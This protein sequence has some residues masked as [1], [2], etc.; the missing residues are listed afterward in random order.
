MEV[1]EHPVERSNSN[2]AVGRLVI[3][4][5][6]FLTGAQVIMIP[7][8]IVINALTARY[9]GAS[10]FGYIYL[11]GTICSF[12]FLVVEWGQAGV[13]PAAIAR[14][15]GQ[16]SAFLGT[17]VAWRVMLV[18]LVYPAL[19]L[20][21]HL[22]GYNAELQ[23][24]LALSFALATLSSFSNAFKDTIRGFERTDLPAYAQ[25][26][27]Q[28]LCALLIAPVLVFGGRMR[29]ALG[30]QVFVAAV[31][32]VVLWPALRLVG[33]RTLSFQRATL[34]SLL[35]EGTPFVF[36]NL[37][38]ALQPNIDAVFLSRLAPDEVMGWFAVTRRLLGVL[39]F[40]ASALLSALYPT[41]SRLHVSDQEMFNRTVRGSLY[42]IALLVVPVALGCA[43]YPEIGIS[44]FSRESFGPAEDNL[45]VSALFLFLVYFSM[46]L[47]TCI[48]AAGKQRA[49]SVV[50]SLC[51]LVSLVLDPILVPVFQRRYGN[52]GL[53]LCVAGV[54]SELLVV[55]CGIALAPKGIFDRRF[56]RLVGLAVLSGVAMALTA[57]GL[58]FLSLTPFLAAPLAVLVY[59]GALLL[60]GAIDKN[61]VASVRSMLGRKFSRP[62]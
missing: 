62:R 32:V 1:P 21:C 56:A 22:F 40:P 48:L 33:V 35:R 9:L 51:V 54:V 47:G 6:L 31:V 27:Q 58:K 57:R 50:Q 10:E 14:D 4:N 44:I 5:T 11:A 43:L 18:G 39:L 19:A 34:R 61:Q 8:S 23:W 52:G 59:G 13:L 45:R 55:G 26:G 30:V 15:H 3:R 29:A 24:A 7:L 60:T 37:A 25:V 36:F 20:G 12:G 42:S 41:L 38:M 28:F 2:A 49:W 46:P 53:G 17:S 16:A